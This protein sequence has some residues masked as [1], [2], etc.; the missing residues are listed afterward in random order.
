MGEIFKFGWAN[1]LIHA[2]MTVFSQVTSLSE[3]HRQI[4]LLSIIYRVAT[5]DPDSTSVWKDND[6]AFY[7]FTG[8][9]PEYFTSPWNPDWFHGA[10][11]WQ[12]KLLFVKRHMR[13][14]R[15]AAGMVDM[16]QT[17]RSLAW[18]KHVRCLDLTTSIRVKS[19]NLVGWAF[20]FFSPILYHWRS[21]YRS[22]SGRWVFY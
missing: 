17:V 14:R 6:R 9:N 18:S 16:Q 19:L 13:L 11:E 3:T 12:V 20:F 7:S 5:D 2:S 10:R 15:S 1:P 22:S 21:R 4:G 8:V